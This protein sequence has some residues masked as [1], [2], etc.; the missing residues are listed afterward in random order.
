MDKQPTQ[1]VKEVRIPLPA[2]LG[3][4]ETFDFEYER[5][6]TA[7]IFLLTYNIQLG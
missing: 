3:Q 4:P 2:K 7:N 6:G 5:N 1:L